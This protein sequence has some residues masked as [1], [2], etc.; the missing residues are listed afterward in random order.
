[1]ISSDKIS[2]RALEPSDA[3]LLY[4]WE[5]NPE[6]T[7]L[8]ESVVPYSKSVLKRFIEGTTDIF[9]D[10]QLR[11]MIELNEDGCPLG[12]VDLFDLDFIH[13]R[14]GVGILI[15]D[16]SDR[17]KGYATET[18][19]LISKYAFNRLHLNQLFCNVLENNHS[20][21]ALFTKSGFT[22]SGI[23][24][25]WMKSETGFIDE[26]LFQKFNPNNKL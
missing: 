19:E 15:A 10:K 3:G 22:L 5:N 24:K 20:S 26:H 8:G 4:K 17:N 7:I 25:A 6:N 16:T 13:G 14:A 9:T 12:C 11:L 1:M 2:L 23:K 18:I 21:I